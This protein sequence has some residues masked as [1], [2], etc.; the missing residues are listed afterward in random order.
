MLAGVFTKDVSERDVFLKIL[1]RTLVGVRPRSFAVLAELSEHG[2]NGGPAQESE[3]RA[4]QALPIL[5]QPPASIEPSDRPLDD[6][7]LR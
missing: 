1:D 6:P 3:C 7:A 5:G 4:V 2:A